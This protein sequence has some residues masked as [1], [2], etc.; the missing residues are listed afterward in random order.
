MRRDS[1]ARTSS[2]ALF[3]LATMWNRSRMCRASEH[4]SRMTLR[5]GS[6]ISEQTK[7]ILEASSSPM[8]AKNPW[9][10][11][12]GSFPAYPQQPGD[13]QIDLVHQREV[14]VTFSVLNLVDA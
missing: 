3:I 6:H 7:A 9:K 8:T 11:S 13:A 2:R 1:P 12:D 10:D 4:F 5:Y 14:F